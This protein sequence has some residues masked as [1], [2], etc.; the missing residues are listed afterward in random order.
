MDKQTQF[1]TAFNTAKDSYD[2]QKGAQNYLDFLS[3]EDGKFYQ[4]VLLETFLNHLNEN[5]EN[6]TDQ[7]ILDAG[8]GPGWMTSELHKTYYN[9][10][11]CDGSSFFINHAKKEYPQIKFDQVDLNLPLPYS[12]NEFG[13]IILSMASDN[14][15][16]QADAFKEMF[17][18]LK[19]NGK[20]MLAVAN[21][22]Y[23]YP[24]GIWKRGFWGR[25]LMRKPKLL[26]KPYHWLSGKFNTATNAGVKK[27]VTYNSNLRFYF[28]TF[29]E[30]MNNLRKSGLNFEK[31]EELG[32]K[33]DSA[34]YNMEYRMHR[35]PVLIYLEFKKP[36]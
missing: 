12:D 7:K 25:L 21:P 10:Q 6:K 26:V 15:E 19:P 18:C 9:I 31:L 5:G 17:R 22:Y 13:S 20:L 36:V 35:F 4:K 16:N 34:N 30:L 27:Q 1:N 2:T 32:S 23:A 8:C 14:L 11:G 3:S 28:Y 24:V 33:E 29:S